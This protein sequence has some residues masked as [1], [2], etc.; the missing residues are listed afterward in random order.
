MRLLG[1]DRRAYDRSRNLVEALL[2]QAERL[3]GATALLVDEMVERGG[4]H[5]HFLL[6]RPQ[7]QQFGKVADR[8]ADLL[9][10]LG[11]R[12]KLGIGRPL[13]YVRR[14]PVLE[15]VEALVEIVPAPVDRKDGLLARQRVQRRPHLLDLEPQHVD[16]SVVV[17]FGERLHRA[18]ETLDVEAELAQ[19]LAGTAGIDAV[20][21]LA[22]ALEFAPHA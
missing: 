13:P 11:Q 19:G 7:R 5:A 6:Q 22:Q 8:L 9:Q 2:D 3:A 16:A 18:R 20:D 1:G 21:V 12:G 15:I 14:H 17:L 4:K 10:A